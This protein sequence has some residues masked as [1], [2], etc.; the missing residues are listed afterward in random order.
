MKVLVAGWFSFPKMGAT[1]GDFLARDVVCGWLDEA[2]RSYDVALADPFRNGVDWQAVDANRYSD[3]VFVCGPFGNGWPIP[4]FIARFTGRRLIGVNLSMLEPL[5]HWNPFDLLLERDSSRLLRPDVSLLAPLKRVPVVGI[6]RVHIQTE[7]P[8]GLHEVAN[9][10][11]ERLVASRAMAAVPIDTRLDVNVTGLRS[12]AEIE[13]L[14]ARMDVVLTTRLHGLVVAIKNGVPAVVVDP[15]GQGAKVLRQ[16]KALSWKVVFTA[17]DLS[18][19]ALTEAFDWALTEDARVA[20]SN[21]RE[22]GVGRL[23]EARDRFLSAFAG[24]D[25]AVEA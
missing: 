13:S 22:R 24:C 3:V 21:C 7:Y 6:V 2:G 12:A 15:I 25:S 16:A 23:Q 14:I 11:I 17:D 5:E 19:V 10:A 9:R 1:A 8:E 4:E 18:D 20:A